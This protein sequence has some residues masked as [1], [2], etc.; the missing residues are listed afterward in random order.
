MASP[1]AAL[2]AGGTW[3]SCA[4]VGADSRPGQHAAQALGSYER[5]IRVASVKQQ[6]LEKSLLDQQAEPSTGSGGDR[7]ADLVV[8]D[9][10]WLQRCLFLQSGSGS[11][12]NCTAC[13]RAAPEVSFELCKTETRKKMK[14]NSDGNRRRSQRV[15]LGRFSVPPAVTPVAFGAVRA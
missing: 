3:G 6:D 14:A 4:V 5:V 9:T 13:L 15:G 2:A 8:A 12:P 1:Q 7:V 10:R 11:P